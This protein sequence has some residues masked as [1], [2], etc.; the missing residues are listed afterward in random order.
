MTFWW[1]RF[2][3]APKTRFY[4]VFRRKTYHKNPK[5]RIYLVF[6]RKKGYSKLKI[7]FFGFIQ[8]T[9]PTPR[10]MA[11]GQQTMPWYRN[12]WRF[13]FSFFTLAK[14]VVSKFFLWRRPSG[15]QSNL[16]LNL[17]LIMCDAN[18]FSELLL[19]LDQSWESLVQPFS[20]GDAPLGDRQ[21]SAQF[22]WDLCCNF[23]LWQISPVISV[24]GIPVS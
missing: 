2:L 17:G 23:F 8:N 10:Q 5:I 6:W 18:C 4:P 14:W 9:D 7:R 13:L 3:N 24:M 11:N 19:K 20:H 22:W 21:I 12:L 16:C 15:G 1:N